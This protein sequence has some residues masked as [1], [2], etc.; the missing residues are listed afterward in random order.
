MKH[1]IHRSA[2]EDN[3]EGFAVVDILEFLLD[4]IINVSN[5]SLDDV[6]GIM[7]T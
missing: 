4:E 2:F 5:M 7:H 1:P 6:E 3:L